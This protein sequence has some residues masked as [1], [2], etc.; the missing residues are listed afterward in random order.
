MSVLHIYGTRNKSLTSTNLL[1]SFSSTKASFSIIQC[2]VLI[3]FFINGFSTVSTLSGPVGDRTK[4]K[5][6]GEKDSYCLMGSAA[7]L[8]VMNDFLSEPKSPT[9]VVQAKFI[10]LYKHPPVPLL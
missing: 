4:V 6:C 5:L 3:S 2:T 10:S 1:E 8:D 9:E 7:L